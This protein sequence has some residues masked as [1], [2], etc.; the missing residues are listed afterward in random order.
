MLLY[1]IMKKIFNLF[2][3]N[4]KALK[5]EMNNSDD[6]DNMEELNDVFL[7]DEDEPPTKKMNCNSN[8]IKLE[9]NKDDKKYNK[10]DDKTDQIDVKELEKI[11]FEIYKSNLM[12][13][14]KWQ[15]RNSKFI[16]PIIHNK[17]E[18][19][20]LDLNNKKEYYKYQQPDKEKYHYYSIQ[21]NIYYDKYKTYL[22]K[23]HFNIL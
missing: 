14:V 1:N 10:Q 7:T 5:C 20:F 3:P 12:N 16:F 18:A 17:Y 19:E 2:Y 15:R 11:T 13:N 23:F 4:N 8:E 21:T 6:T 9:N 22:K